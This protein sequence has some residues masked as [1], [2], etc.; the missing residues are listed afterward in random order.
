MLLN[1]DKKSTTTFKKTET[2]KTN[3]DKQNIAQIE[4]NSDASINNEFYLK[5]GRK[6]RSQSFISLLKLFLGIKSP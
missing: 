5:H 6:L 1:Q 2:H 3:I 4:R